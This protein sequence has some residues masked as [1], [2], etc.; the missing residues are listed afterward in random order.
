LWF[1]AGP[2][3]SKRPYLKNKL[4]QKGGGPGRVVEGL[5]NKF[6]PQAERERQRE[7]SGSCVASGF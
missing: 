4:K 2:S 5:P 7:T 6:K 3:K 1:E